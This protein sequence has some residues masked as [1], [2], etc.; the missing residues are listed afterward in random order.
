MDQSPEFEINPSSCT[1]ITG[2]K[3]YHERKFHSTAG[4]G[5]QGE[6]SVATVGSSHSRLVYAPELKLPV[7]TG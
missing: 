4:G 5:W 2:Y 3:L 6:G 1:S 7:A